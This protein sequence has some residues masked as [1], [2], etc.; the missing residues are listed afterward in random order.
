MSQPC[1]VGQKGKYWREFIFWDHVCKGNCVLASEILHTYQQLVR[2]DKTAL[3]L[4]LMGIPDPDNENG[5][6]Y[7]D[8]G[9]EATYL[10]KI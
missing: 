5:K 8:V 4:E 1:D 9:S 3:P 6:N 2:N 10:Q 7:V